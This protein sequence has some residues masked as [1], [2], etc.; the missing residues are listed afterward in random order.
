MSERPEFK[1]LGD[2]YVFRWPES[3]VAA[4][5]E[6]IVE[7]DGGL[8]VDLTMSDVTNPD[9]PG[10]LYSARLN[11]MAPNSKRSLALQLS[12]RMDADFAGILE[13]ITLLTRQHYQQ[14]EPVVD[15]R[16]VFPRPSATRWLLEPFV[17]EGSGATIVF[18][19]GGT[20]KSVLALAMG[21][22]VSTGQPILGQP[23]GE[24]RPVYYLDWEADEF[25]HAMRMRAILKGA[26]ITATPPMFYHRQVASLPEAISQIRRNI[27]EKNVGLVIIDSMGAAAGQEPE[28]AQTAI[29]FFRAA[30]SMRVPFI[31]IH[32]KPKSSLADQKKPFGSAY[33]HNLARI[34]WSLEKVQ[35]AGADESIVDFTNCKNNNG[36]LLKPKAY[37]L[38]FVNS[39]QDDL[40]EIRVKVV[41]R[42]SVSELREKM[43]LKERLLQELLSNGK[44]QLDELAELVGKKPA[45]VKPR[46]Y[47]LKRAGKVDRFA[48]GAWYV[49]AGGGSVPF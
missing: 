1:V 7:R 9:R 10:V 41:D 8:L 21:L 26:G 3:K 36:R 5:V 27:A 39:D 30:R 28:A 47:D 37:K 2:L 11:L 25:I 45:D 40:E 20:G 46:L 42:A 17:E 22:S 13:Q 35:D 31:G 44:M 19:D 38:T 29:E 6:R 34:T 32:H 23:K 4:E 49:V 15:L 14:G 24:P 48:D 12:E 18:A 33:F 43:P 16:N